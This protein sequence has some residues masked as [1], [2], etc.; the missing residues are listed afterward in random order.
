MNSED[1]KNKLKKKFYKDVIEVFDTRGSGDHFSIIIVSD[2]FINISLVDRHKIIYEIFKKEITN[3]IHALQI[4]T[5]TKKEWKKK[6][7]SN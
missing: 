6:N 5:Y 4:Q 2:K 7:I 3:Q 1:I